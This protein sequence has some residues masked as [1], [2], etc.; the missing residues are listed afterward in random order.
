MTARCCA[1]QGKPLRKAAAAALAVLLLAARP[2]PSSAEGNPLVCVMTAED[3]GNGYEYL[4]QGIG[5]FTVNCQDGETVPIL[6][7]EAYD[8]CRAVLYRDGREV[9]SDGLVYDPGLYELRIYRDGAED[10]DYGSFHAAVKNEY[11]SLETGKAPELEE[12]RNPVLALSWDAGRK[13]FRYTFPDGVWFETNIPAGGWSRSAARITADDSLHIYQIY[14]DGEVEG[15]G[16]GT[17][18]NETGGYELILRDNELGSRGTAAYY[19]VMSFRLYKDETLCLSRVN[20]PMGLKL[21][22][23]KRD[24]ESEAVEDADSIQLEKDGR[25]ELEYADG[26]GTVCWRMEFVRDTTPP[27]LRFSVPVDEGPVRE[28]VS[29][30]PSEL[31]ARVRLERNGSETTASLNIIRVNGNY[32]MEVSDRA[33]NCREYDFT[34]EKRTR[35]DIRTA[36]LTLAAAALLLA[37][38][39]AYWRRSM[40]VR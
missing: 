23:V 2:F 33:G 6:V 35:I 21:V 36:V 7:Y 30:A 32:H 1:G 25:Y 27:Q 8:G 37:G 11:S 13:V 5:T 15:I 19:A 9:E 17:A 31:D 20:S 39:M 4:V 22:S 26:T 18:F 10:G 40:R 3:A 34:V 28:D 12:V 16:N 24:G 29:F 38:G 14:K